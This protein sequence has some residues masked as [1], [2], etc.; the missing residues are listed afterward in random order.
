MIRVMTAPAQDSWVMTQ[1]YMME[2][3]QHTPRKLINESVWTHR[4]VSILFK[5]FLTIDPGDVRKVGID[6][7]SRRK[8]Q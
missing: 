8:T 6:A 3:A 4:K 7:V 1:P 2:R 5:L